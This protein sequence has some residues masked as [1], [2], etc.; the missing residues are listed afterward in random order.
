MKKVD[1]LQVI[2]T[3]AKK[4]IRNES[5][6]ISGS[7]SYTDCRVD[8]KVEAEGVEATRSLNPTLTEAQE[9]NVVSLITQLLGDI[10]TQEGV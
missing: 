10:K 1:V 7:V 3:P 4:P 5:G 9:T 2:L 8:Y 6:G